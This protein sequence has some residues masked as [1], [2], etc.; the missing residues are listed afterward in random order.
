MFAYDYSLGLVIANVFLVFQTNELEQ[1][2][3]RR[4]TRSDGD[5]PWFRI[6]LGVVNGD[7]NIHVAEIFPMESFDHVQGVGRWLAELIEPYF[8]VETNSIDD[9]CIAFPPA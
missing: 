5:G 4:Q 2:R 7:L 3:V 6:R 8:P 1:L 9:E